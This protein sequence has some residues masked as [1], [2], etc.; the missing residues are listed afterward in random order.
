M[1][2]NSNVKA[3]LIWGV[4]IWA[5]LTVWLVHDGCFK[6]GGQC[7]ESI[8]GCGGLFVIITSI[9]YAIGEMINKK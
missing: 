3:L 1:N 2:D 8:V 9:S 5:A 7:V 6:E 4:I